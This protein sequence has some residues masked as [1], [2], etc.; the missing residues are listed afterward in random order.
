MTPTNYTKITNKELIE[1]LETEI[2][3]CEQHSIFDTYPNWESWNAGFKDALILILDKITEKDDK[4]LC[5][6]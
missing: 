4:T 6:T 2:E 5:L 1:F 3:K